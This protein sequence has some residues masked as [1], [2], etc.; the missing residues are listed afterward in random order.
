MNEAVATQEGVTQQDSPAVSE[1]ES[2]ILSRFRAYADGEG[3]QAEPPVE[4]RDP[5]QSDAQADAEPETPAVQTVRVKIDGEEREVP[6]DEVVTAYQKDAAASKRFEEAARVRREADEITSKVNAERQ[7]LQAALNEF[8]ARAE[9]FGPKA[10]DLSLLDSDPVEYVRQEALHKQHVQQMQEARAAQTYLTQQQQREFEQQHSQRLSQERDALLKALPHWSDEG[11]AKADKERVSGYL[12]GMGFDEQTIGSV[13][14]HRLV[15]MAREAA[16]YRE[17][18]SKAKETPK[19]VAK[20]PARVERP[21]VAGSALD[22]RTAAMQRLT[23]SGK[24]EDAA[25]L[26]KSL[27]DAN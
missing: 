18:M 26:F 7:Q 14:D 10:P 4:A 12:R 17:I 23:R 19:Q 1:S 2:D 24:A 9:R 27:L 6:V 25:A 21:G 20:A 15:V 8:T 3:Q 5:E 13:S 11:K 22:G 16:L